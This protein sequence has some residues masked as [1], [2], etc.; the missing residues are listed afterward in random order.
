MHN[1]DK[2][3]KINFGILYVVATPIG[4]INDITKRAIEVLSNSYI[5]ATENTRHSKRLL[6]FYGIKTKLISYHKYNEVERCNFLI[7]LLLKGKSISV[8]SDAGT[9]SIS[10]P[11][12]IIIS[13]AHRKNIRVCPIPGASSIIAAISASG[14]A[15]D[16]FKFIGFLP[17]KN[18]QKTD[19]L[20]KNRNI[21]LIFFES[22]NRFLKTLKDLQSIYNYKK[23][24]IVA[25]EITKIHEDINYDYLDNQIKYFSKNNNEKIKGEFTIIIPKEEDMD[26][27][28][29]EEEVENF[30]ILLLENKVIYNSAIKITCKHFSIKKNM[31]YKKYLHLANK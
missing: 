13:E 28:I 23:K 12:D 11:G 1:I 27:N 21:S 19:I 4:N 8:I 10:D 31:I 7:N 25:K 9:P 20:K 16:D 30:I 6:N 17:K 18:A 29:S 24:I 14:F 15:S 2:N 5:I 3:K 26:V 22:P